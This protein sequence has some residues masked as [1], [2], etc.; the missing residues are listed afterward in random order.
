MGIH[1]IFSTIYDMMVTRAAFPIIRLAK[2]I[3]RLKVIF[4]KCYP[5]KELKE[6]LELLMDCV[7]RIYTS[8]SPLQNEY[9]YRTLSLKMND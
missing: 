8:P 3:C 4:Q 1:L 5:D 9:E 6:A 2:R 7:G